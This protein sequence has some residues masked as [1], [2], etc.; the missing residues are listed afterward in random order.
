MMKI[1]FYR[2]G[3]TETPITPAKRTGFA[4]RVASFTPLSSDCYV[5]SARTPENHVS[6]R[7]D[8]RE[9][10]RK[11]LEYAA[12]RCMPTA[13][14]RGQFW[15]TIA[16]DVAAAEPDYYQRGRF[17]HRLI[18]LVASGDVDGQQAAGDSAPW[19]TADRGG[20]SGIG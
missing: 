1:G 11:Q 19:E 14:R 13:R 6:N 16:A 7:G 17:I 9:M 20:L 5:F 12:I 2:C 8:K 3:V 18:G 4:A 15:P 10:N